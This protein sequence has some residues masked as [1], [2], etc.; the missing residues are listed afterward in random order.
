M[1]SFTI[2]T[3]KKAD[4]SK[5]RYSGGRYI[6]EQPSGAAKKVYTKVCH[7]LKYKCP[8]SLKIHIKETT[9]GSNKK[10]YFYRITKKKQIREVERDGEIIIYNFITKIK[11]IKPF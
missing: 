4:G 11:S 3:V 5:V 6:S 2:E 10:D 8:S 7:Y 9:Q 1:R